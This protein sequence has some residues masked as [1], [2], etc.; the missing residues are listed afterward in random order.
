LFLIRKQLTLNTFTI[1]QLK[2][3]MIIRMLN[4]TTSLCS[5]KN[6]QLQRDEAAVARDNFNALCVHAL[7]GVL[8]NR[9]HDKRGVEKLWR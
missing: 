2:K 8:A 6:I 7:R 9:S 5:T 4:I 3:G 1:L